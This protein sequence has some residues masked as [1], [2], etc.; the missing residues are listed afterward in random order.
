MN[1]HWSKFERS[2]LANMIIGNKLGA[3]MN[4]SGASLGEYP[5]PVA[6]FFSGKKSSE[7]N[8]LVPRRC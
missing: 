6:P 3:R 7:A 8:P 2:I 4:L 5:N 1:S